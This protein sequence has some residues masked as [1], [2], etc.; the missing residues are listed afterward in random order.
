MRIIGVDPGSKVTGYGVVEYSAGRVVHVAHGVLR[1]ARTASLPARL[2]H[3]HH[4]L[5]EIVA[6]HSP[7][8]AVVEKVFVA[9]NAGSALV[10]GQARG[11]ALAA[12]AA[13]GLGVSE[14][15]AREVKKAVVGDGGATK[16]Q[17][18]AG[19]GSPPLRCCSP[20]RS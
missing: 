19:A 14:L 7:D 5:S 18:P 15:T 16:A 13:A 20:Y 3:I 10:L 8:V 1:P 2:A 12:L 6:C 17:V 4:G 9:A 11:A